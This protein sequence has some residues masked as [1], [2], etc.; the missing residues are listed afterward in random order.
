MTIKTITTMELNP[1][2]V[3]ALVTLL[4]GLNGSDHDRLGTSDEDRRMLSE[5]FAQLTKGER[6]QKN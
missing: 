5:M 2:E 6:V 4:G 1:A 3:E